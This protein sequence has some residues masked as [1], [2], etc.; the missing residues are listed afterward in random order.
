[1]KIVCVFNQKGGVGKTTT[2]VNLAAYVAQKGFRVLVIDIDP[3][4]NTTSGF[5]VDK[6]SLE[7]TTYDLLLSDAAITTTIISMENIENISIIPSNMDLAGADIELATMPDRERILKKKL[8]AVAEDFDY[9]F[10]DCPPS[11]G[12]LTINALT[13]AHSVIIPM[14][15]EYYALEGISQLVK[16]INLVK[17][18]L[19]KDLEIEGV[20][21]TMF[22]GRRNLQ[23]QVAEELKSYFGELV[24]ENTIP[25]NIR[26]AEAPSH[27]MPIATYDGKCKGAEA[28]SD[29]SDEFLRKQ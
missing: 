7:N 24:Y 20:V 26:L 13:A 8:E 25:R 12:L 11:L 5:G 14:Q 17:K 3:Q 9:V 22:D 1:M 16:T 10:I 27:G 23:I 15:C 19:N 18:G 29:L 6:E 2:N 4:G 21:L 28:Y